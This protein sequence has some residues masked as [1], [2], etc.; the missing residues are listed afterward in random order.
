[1]KLFQNMIWPLNIALF[2][3]LLAFVFA[4]SGRNRC[5]AALSLF[6]FFFLGTLSLPVV[7]Y[8]LMHPLDNYY[9]ARP[10]SAY[11]AADAIVVLGGTVGPRQTANGQAEERAGSRL[12]AAVRLFKAKK[13][14]RIIVTSGITYP[15][16]DGAQRTEAEDMRDI[17]VDMG[18][19]PYVILLEN[20]AK[21]TEENARFSAELLRKRGGNHIFLVSSAHHLRR[22]VLWFTKSG[23]NVTPVSAG[24]YV[25]RSPRGWRDFVPS[26]NALLRSTAAIKEYLGFAVANSNTCGELD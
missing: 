20:R 25:Q 14:E 9:E 1:M 6:V 22:A 13:A 11:P 5:S 18:V 21:N 17:L 12:L 10:I 23:L 24:A 19:S 2:C 7:S 15:T 3:T 4:A 26:A 16:A 8:T